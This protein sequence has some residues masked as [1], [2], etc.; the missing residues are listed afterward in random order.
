[1]RVKSNHFRN[2]RYDPPWLCR[3]QAASPL[4]LRRTASN[5]DGIWAIVLQG[6]MSTAQDTHKVNRWKNAVAFIWLTFSLNSKPL[7]KRVGLKWN[8]R[9]SLRVHNPPSSQITGH[10]NKVPIEIKSLSLLIGSGGDRQHKHR[11]F[12]FH[13]NP[14]LSRSSRESLALTWWLSSEWMELKAV[15]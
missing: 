3:P 5:H 4:R 13:Y 7:I 14:V 11:L 10:L 15:C 1:M 2:W 8:V 6:E 12:R 9:R